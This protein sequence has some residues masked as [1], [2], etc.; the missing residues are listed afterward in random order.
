MFYI[1]QEVSL[2]LLLEVTGGSARVIF[3]AFFCYT[4]HPGDTI[5]TKKFHKNWSNNLGETELRTH[6]HAELGSNG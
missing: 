5:S 2:Y 3:F 4:D 6:A 1:K